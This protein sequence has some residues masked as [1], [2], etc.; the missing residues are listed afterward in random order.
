MTGV[1]TCALPISKA[2]ENG[3]VQRTEVFKLTGDTRNYVTLTLPD[4]VTYHSG[5]TTKTGSV[6]IYGGTSFYFSAPMTVM[7]TWKSGTLSGQI[8]SQWKTLVVSTGNGDQDIG[9]GDFYEEANGS[10]NFTVTWM[11][12]AKVKVTKKDDA[13]GVNLAGAVFGI[14]S[15]KGC[16]NLITKMPETD[17]QGATEVQIPKTQSTVYLKED[18]KSVV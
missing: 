6:K 5:S 13:T 10:V 14:Y 1:Q 16:T 17:A 2:Y 4:N 18:R 9:Y 11:E 7:G 3:G 15:D 8:G 12:L